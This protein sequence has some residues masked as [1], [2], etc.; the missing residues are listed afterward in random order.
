MQFSSGQLCAVL[1]AVLFGVS[2]VFCK[3]VIGDMSPALLAGL[4]YLGSGLG[5]QGVLLAQKKS[6]LQELRGLTLRHRLK[7][8]GAVV[9]G[10]VIAPVCLAY[11]IKHG[12]ASEVS[13]LL[14][15]ET[16]ATTLIAWLVFREYIGPYVWSGKVLILAGAG[17]VVL[18][19][20]GALTFSQPG[21]LVVIACVFWGIDNNLTRDVDEISS[22]VLA[23]VKGL[24]AGAFSVLLAL[25]FPGGAVT[26]GQVMGTMSIGAVSYGLSL[27][28]FVEA[29][30]RIGAARTATFFAVGPFFGTLLSVVLLGERPPAAYWVATALM[31]SGIFLLYLEVHCHRH[32]HEDLAHAHPHVHDEHHLHEHEEGEEGEPHHHLHVHHPVTHTHVH[33]PDPHHRHGH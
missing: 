18:K 15:L 20:Q 24:C 32:T 14:N 29:L 7:L 17:L 11:G 23:S 8:A 9:A 19:A 26:A 10:G 27:V 28:L 25:I 3:L 13:L 31:L 5:L 16:V 1:A 30:R 6:S 12:T 33:A 4:L 21:L 2:P 22:T